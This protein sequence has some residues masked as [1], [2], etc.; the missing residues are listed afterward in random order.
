VSRT[1]AIPSPDKAE[2]MTNCAELRLHTLDRIFGGES[3][4]D[5]AP[6]SRWLR[7]AG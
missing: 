7:R 4:H 6:V 3:A 1:Y 2:T 5:A